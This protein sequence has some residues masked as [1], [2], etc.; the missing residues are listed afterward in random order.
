MCKTKERRKAKAHWYQTNTAPTNLPYFHHQLP[1]FLLACAM[2]N[3]L[4][5]SFL[6][7]SCEYR[8]FHRHPW[9]Y[10]RSCHWC[11]LK[12]AGGFT[13]MSVH[14]AGLLL[15]LLSSLCLRDT[16]FG[17]PSHSLL[18]SNVSS[19]GDWR[20]KFIKMEFGGLLHKITSIYIC[21]L[22][23]S[24]LYAFYHLILP[25]PVHAKFQWAAVVNS[26]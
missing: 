9:C 25:L 1:G 13:Y 10:C 12:L 15:Q 16:I 2:H 22:S 11:K 21:C 6:S 3:L 26:S 17:P 23:L 4:L 14:S 24:M 7:S 19:H 20:A 5:M 8:F 18:S